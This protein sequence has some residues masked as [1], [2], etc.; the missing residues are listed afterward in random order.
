MFIGV[1]GTGALIP[2]AICG[3]GR[4]TGVPT[5][6]TRGPI[7][8]PIVGGPY[9]PTPEGVTGVWE[10][11]L[12]ALLEAPEEEPFVWPVMGVWDTET[13]PPLTLV[14]S[15]MLDRLRS[16]FIEFKRI[17]YFCAW[18]ATCVGVLVTTKFRDMLR[19]SPLPYFSKPRR[20]NLFLQK[21]K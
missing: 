4:L 9:M 8:C 1:P 14:I 10:G 21:R 3:G 19:Q 16:L 18:L 7:G 13:S 6:E 5:A 17:K 20:N 12:L 15:W 11:G 2:Y